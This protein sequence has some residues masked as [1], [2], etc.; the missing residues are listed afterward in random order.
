MPTIELQR[1]EC[2]EHEQWVCEFIAYASI[3][4]ELQLLKQ[5]I[6]D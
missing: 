5:E 1:L 3:D 2:I 4:T 6:L